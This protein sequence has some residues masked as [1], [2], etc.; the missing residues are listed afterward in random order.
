MLKDEH[1]SFLL[2][3]GNQLTEYVF[4]SQMLTILAYLA[5][6]FSNLNKLNG[7]IRCSTINILQPWDNFYIFR[8]NKTSTWEKSFVKVAGVEI[9]LS[10]QPKVWFEEVKIHYFAKPKAR[11]NNY[12]GMQ[13]FCNL[14]SDILDNLKEYYLNSISTIEFLSKTNQE[15]WLRSL[16]QV[17]FLLKNEFLSLTWNFMGKKLLSHVCFFAVYTQCISMLSAYSLAFCPP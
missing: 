8:K 11:F 6:V 4:R 14:I 2:N 9:F 7:I 13:V 1:R 10:E 5:V 17:I 3:A 16:Y 15:R 12:F